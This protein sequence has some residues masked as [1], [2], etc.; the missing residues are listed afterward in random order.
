MRNE[1]TRETATSIGLLILRLGIAGYMLTH[2]W[3]KFQMVLGGE[4][5]Q[6]GDPIGLGSALSLILVFI[7][8]FVCPILIIVGLGTRIAAIF[9]VAAMGVAAFVA[10]G[11]DP[12]TMGGGAQIFYSG[13]SESWASKEPAL[14]FLIVFLALVF[15]GAGRYSIDEI[16]RRRRRA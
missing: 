13:A 3:G 2:G 4:L 8:E 11:G 9:P 7:A 12:W 14:L 16:I 1:K 5:D 15:T 6:F 10:H